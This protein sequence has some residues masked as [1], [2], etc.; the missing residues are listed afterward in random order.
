MAERNQ[1]PADLARYTARYLSKAQKKVF[2]ASVLTDIFE[3]AYFASMRTEE[4]HGITCTLAVVDYD[5]PDSNPPPVRRLHRA[6]FY[7]FEDELQFSVKNLVKLAQAA[8]PAASEI[9]ISV[10]PTGELVILGIV[11]QELQHRHWVA[12]EADGR[13]GRLGLLQVEV[14][15]IAALS[16][17]KDDGL[18]GGLRQNVLVTNFLDVLRDGP[19]AD[20]LRLYTNALVDRVRQAVGPDYD[21]TVWWS[22]DD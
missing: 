13:F 16:V 5:K 2:T 14:T 12:H 17:Y 22:F 11:D 21:R 7:R 3:I 20:A 4:S 18:I 6:V 19:V 9:A 15:G 1:Y 10:N 8:D